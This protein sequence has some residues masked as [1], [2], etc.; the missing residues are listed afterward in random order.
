LD[1]TFAEGDL[2]APVEGPI[3]AVLSNPPYVAESD[4]AS[5]APEITSHEPDVAVFAGAD[6]LDLV[7]RLIAG[8]A[9]TGARMLAMEIGMGQGDVVAALLRD[10][11]FPE[12]SLTA[13][14]AGIPRV[15]VGRR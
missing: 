5:L 1:V 4:R 15:V 13:D 7:R 6:G 12:T 8:T 10:A 9:A 11:G 3:D 2:L 14:L